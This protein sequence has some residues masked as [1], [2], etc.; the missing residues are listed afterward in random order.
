MTNASHRKTIE[1]MQ[2]LAGQDLEEADNA[3]VRA[4][5]VED[6]LDPGGEARHVAGLL[7]AI[8]A[9]FMRDR[10]AA[11]KALR[12]TTTPAAPLQRPRIERMKALIRAAFANE[13]QLAAA[14]REG[15]A[16]T[17]AD[18]QSLYDDLVAMGKIA[19]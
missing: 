17:D 15:K 1:A 11:A 13:P 5:F 9:Q 14:F 12:A 4:E 7:D 16:Q 19:G 8:V 18:V 6:G 10:A 3:Q 2:A